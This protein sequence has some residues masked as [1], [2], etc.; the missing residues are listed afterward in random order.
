MVGR[1]AISVH[2]M[3]RG[4]MIDRSFFIE[5]LAQRFHLEP[6]VIRQVLI[7][8]LVRTPFS[9]IYKTTG[10]SLEVISLIWSMRWK[11]VF[12]ASEES[13]SPE[14]AD[15]W[16][17][18]LNPSDAAS[19]ILIEQVTSLLKVGVS[20]EDICQYLGIP[21]EQ[22]VLILSLLARKRRAPVHSDLP[23]S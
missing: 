12:V 16:P 1:T 8:F 18:P 17:R 23:R 6:S 9:R 7:A 19:T 13:A 10:V 3:Q 22:F 21:D 20:N 2:H 14:R 5:G 15:A 4:T 11:D